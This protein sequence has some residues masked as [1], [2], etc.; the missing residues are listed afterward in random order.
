MKKMKLIF[1]KCIQCLDLITTFG[2]GLQFIIGWIYMH[3]LHTHTLTHAQ[4][5]K[6]YIYIYSLMSR[7]RKYNLYWVTLRCDFFL[8]YHWHLSSTK[9]NILT[10]RLSNIHYKLPRIQ[11]K[12]IYIHGKKTR[13][14]TN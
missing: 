7:L 8:I 5:Y 1:G 10:R 14:K 4:I 9:Q 2:K 3:I 12:G 6:E 13:R 11:K